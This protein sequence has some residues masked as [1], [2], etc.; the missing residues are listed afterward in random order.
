MITERRLETSGV[1]IPGSP[2]PHV[3]LHPSNPAKPQGL[4]HSHQKGFLGSYGNLYPCPLPR[5]RGP[6]ALQQKGSAWESPPPRP[7]SFC[8]MET[9]QKQRLE[10]LSTYQSALSFLFMGEGRRPCFYCGQKE[11]EGWG[12]KGWRP[13]CVEALGRE[14][15]QGRLGDGQR[16]HW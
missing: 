11:G 2:H 3:A 13:T 14:G 6:G 4:G 1:Q 5:P 15:T 8:S 16:S 12:K 7:P 10:V 9:V